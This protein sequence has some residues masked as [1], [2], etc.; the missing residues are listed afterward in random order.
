MGEIRCFIE[1][2]E[3][4]II[5]CGI[6][7]VRGTE[8]RRGEK[9]ARRSRGAKSGAR[10]MRREAYTVVYLD[11]IRCFRPLVVIS[12]KTALNRRRAE[13]YFFYRRIVIQ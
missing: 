11:W 6:P 9:L 5:Y 4:S 8:R 2:D 7:R 1:F 3:L 13:P 12:C 10:Y